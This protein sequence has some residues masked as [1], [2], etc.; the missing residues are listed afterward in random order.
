MFMGEYNHTVDGKGRVIV[1]SKF[2]EALGEEFV[3]TKGLDGCL[4]VYPMDEWQTFAEKMKVLP[5]ASKNTRQFS[6]YFLSGAVTCELDKQGRILLPNNLREFA[7]LE[8]DVVFIGVSTRVEIWSK[9]NWDASMAVCDEDMDE[10]AESL[11]ALG[12]GI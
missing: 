11:A 9:E 2:R 6:R 12:F 10:I 8:K 5:T 7:E 1:P 4:F 3:V